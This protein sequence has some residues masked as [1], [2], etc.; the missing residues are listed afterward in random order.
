MYFMDER[1]KEEIYIYNGLKKT[2]DGVRDT[3]KKSYLLN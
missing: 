3:L 1:Q 2:F